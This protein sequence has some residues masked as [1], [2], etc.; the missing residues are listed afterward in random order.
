M[1]AATAQRPSQI[2]SC[3]GLPASCF[4]VEVCADLHK[5]IDR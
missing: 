3:R 2:I 1:S 5:D 4:L